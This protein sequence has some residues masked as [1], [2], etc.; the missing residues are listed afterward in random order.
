MTGTSDTVTLFSNQRTD[1]YVNE[2]TDGEITCA[3]TLISSKGSIELSDNKLLLI[4][5]ASLLFT[6]IAVSP[7]MVLMIERRNLFSTIEPII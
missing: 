1:K 6:I 2:K 3:R 7:N 4:S 5:K